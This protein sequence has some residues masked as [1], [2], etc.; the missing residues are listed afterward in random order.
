MKIFFDEFG[1]KSSAIVKCI[2]GLK[3]TI[4]G[5]SCTKLCLCFFKSD[6]RFFLF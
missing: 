6:V 3:L 5:K 2:E 1:V 4:N